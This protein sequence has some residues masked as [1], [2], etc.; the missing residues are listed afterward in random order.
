MKPSNFYLTLSA[1]LGAAFAISAGVF[2]NV[3]VDV[4]LQGETFT[5]CS[6]SAAEALRNWDSHISADEKKNRVLQK[7]VDFLTDEANK[8]L[9]NKILD[10]ATIETLDIL[11]DRI[12]SARLPLSHFFAQT[13]KR[14]EAMSSEIITRARRGIYSSECEESEMEALG[15]LSERTTS[16][17]IA[18]NSA[19]SRLLSSNSYLNVLR[20]KAGL[21]ETGGR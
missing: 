13:N 16:L 4:T 11:A 12:D 14:D 20:L 2:A 5:V 3:L 17:M 15:N 6:P 7:E 19:S 1:T 9:A 10:G 8:I 21:R 18:A